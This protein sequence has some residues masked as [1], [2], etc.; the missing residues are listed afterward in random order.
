MSNIDSII[1][2]VYSGIGI[3]CLITIIVL[4]IRRIR[5]KK[6]EDFEKGAIKFRVKTLG[7]LA[8][9]MKA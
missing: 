5:I 1:V 9:K 3:I 2:S 7:R 4:V 8:I 6:K